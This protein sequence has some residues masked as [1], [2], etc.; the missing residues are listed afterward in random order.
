MIISNLS[1]TIKGLL[2]TNAQGGVPQPQIQTGG[3][4]PPQQYTGG[5]SLQRH[6]INT[7]INNQNL[8]LNTV[9]EIKQVV[10]D[11]QA[12]TDQIIQ[13]QSRQPTAQIQGAGGYDVQSLIVEMRD[14]LNQVKLGVAAVGQK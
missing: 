1:V 8:F 12:R 13:T 3:V 6:E 2:S 9:R 7:I 5:D 10:Q 14:G 11:V 4:P